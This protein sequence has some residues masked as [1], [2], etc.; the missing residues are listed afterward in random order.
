LGGASQ[1]EGVDKNRGGRNLVGFGE[2]VVLERRK[3]REIGKP[4]IRG[5]E[6]KKEAKI[7]KE[8]KKGG[9]LGKV[10]RPKLSH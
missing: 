8:K 4:K 10:H 2:K 1:G 5:R 3:K 7:T 6:G 9:I